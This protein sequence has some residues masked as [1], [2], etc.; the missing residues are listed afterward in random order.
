M[1]LSNLQH[2]PLEELHLA[3]GGKLVPFSG[4]A[5]PVQYQGILAEHQAVRSACGV[6][7]IS[8]MGQLVVEGSDHVNAAEWLD[9]VLTS[10][11]SQ[12]LPGAGQY[13]LLL[14]DRGGIIDDLS[15]YRTGPNLFFLVVNAACRS[16][17]L[18][19]LT[20][21]A[22]PGMALIDRGPAYGAIAVQGPDSVRVASAMLPAG[23][24]LPPRFGCLET[25]EITICRTGY[26]GEDGFE[27]CAP[28]ESLP[29][30]WN[31]AVAA[32]AK[33]CGLGA[34]DLLRLEKCY[35]LNGSDLSEETTPLEAGLGFA[36]DFEKEDF[37]GAAALREQRSRG[38]AR[39]LVA[40]KVPGRTPPPRPGY[41]VHGGD[42]SGP[43][44]GTLTSGGFS[45]VLG[46]SIAMAY[47]PVTFQRPGTPVAI[48][49]RGTCYPA[50]VVRKP[51]I[52]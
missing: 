28:T 51:F 26:T 31:K 19:W 1:D 20:L 12:L 30:W 10:R 25:G 45:P 46:M 29:E 17:D 7:D 11:P 9:R 2:S 33:P 21:N 3:A 4:W 52:P 50:Q 48:E 22:P 38:L 15:V 35:P 23:V 47:V 18:D 8:H 36:V 16:R 39:R 6:F 13:S 43:V 42:A 27:L 5:L 41:A 40:I 14:T 37:V 24:S 34:R 32:G 49:I 44:I